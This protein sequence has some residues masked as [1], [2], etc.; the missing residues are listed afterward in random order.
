VP[1]AV[2]SDDQQEDYESRKLWSKLTQAIK[3]RDMEA[4]TDAKTAVEDHQR[5]LAKER[6]G[7]GPWK[8]RFFDE[9]YDD[10]RLKAL[11]R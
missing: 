10:Y 7:K 8:P 11:K 9:E 2:A 3:D 6:E 1:K 4:A 5:Q